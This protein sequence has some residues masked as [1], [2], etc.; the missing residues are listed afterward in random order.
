MILLRNSYLEFQSL[1]VGINNHKLDQFCELVERL[2]EGR[3]LLET[4]RNSINREELMVG[5]AEVVWRS[6]V[7]EKQIVST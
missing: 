6:S 2:L 4:S 7:H 5:F 1:I 3:N